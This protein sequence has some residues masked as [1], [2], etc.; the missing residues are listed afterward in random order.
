M[1]SSWQFTFKILCLF[2]NSPIILDLTVIEIFY[3]VRKIQQKWKYEAAVNTK[4]YHI[5]SITFI[6]RLMH[7]NIQNVDVK[8][9]VV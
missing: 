4:K 8:I 7:S 3:R 6:S 5:T 2:S 9:Y 1:V